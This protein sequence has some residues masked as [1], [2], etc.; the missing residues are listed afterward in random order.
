MEDKKSKRKEQYRQI[1][2]LASINGD[3]LSYIGE[4]VNIHVK[5]GRRQHGKVEIKVR[6]VRANATIFCKRFNQVAHS[7]FRCRFE[8][9]LVSTYTFQITLDFV[10]HILTAFI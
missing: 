9:I 6:K 3:D 4:N 2:I 8:Y 10:S 5:E 7:G 1:S